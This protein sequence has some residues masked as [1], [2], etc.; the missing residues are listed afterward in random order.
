MISARKLK[1]AG[2]SLIELLVAVVVG[3]ILIAGGLA[4]FRGMRTKQAV[5]QAGIGFQANLRLFQQKA[6]SGEKPT[7]C[8]TNDKLEG[9]WVKYKNSTDYSLQAK[10]GDGTPLEIIITL[11]EE[12]EFDLSFGDLFFPTLKSGIEGAP[13]TITLTKDGFRYAITVEKSGMIKGAML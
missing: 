11:P 1:P 4:G 13:K 2:F 7:G 6:L 9:Y 8:T 5:K 3:G 12:V 10:C